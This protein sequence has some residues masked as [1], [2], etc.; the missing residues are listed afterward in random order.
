MNLKILRFILLFCF[1]VALYPLFGYA[2]KKAGEDWWSLQ[3]IVRPEL[4]ASPSGEVIDGFIDRKL[5]DRGLALAPE[6]NPRDLIRR[7]TYDLTGLPP[8]PD[9]MES[10]LNDASKDAYEKLVDRLLASP[11]YGERWARHWLDVVRFGESHGFEYNQPRQ[12]FWHYRN[13]V[14][15]AFNED[16]PYDR[17]TR[18]QIAGDHFGKGDPDGFIATGCLV[19]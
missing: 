1:G 8:T 13:W 11:H 9:E 2:A 7:V 16:M 12:N 18:W 15:K 6:A 17:F 14:V 19:T 3:P 10:F 4:P 5:K